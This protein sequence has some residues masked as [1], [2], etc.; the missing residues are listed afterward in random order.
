M[1]SLLV[2]PATL[3]VHVMTQLMLQLGQARLNNFVALVHREYLGSWLL[4]R[5][6]V[7]WVV[8]HGLGSICFKATLALVAVEVDSDVLVRLW[9]LLEFA[10]RRGPLRKVGSEI[11]DV[12]FVVNEERG[13]RPRHLQLGIMDL[14]EKTSK[15]PS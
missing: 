11:L 2:L 5:N 3:A 14:S 15:S 8:H 10:H 12:F 13:N 6:D 7:H 1:L 4:G 9:S